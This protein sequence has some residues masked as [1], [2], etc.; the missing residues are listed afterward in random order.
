MATLSKLELEFIEF[1][2]HNVQED[3]SSRATDVVSGVDLEQLK[4]KIAAIIES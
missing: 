3:T 2:L 1:I 4:D